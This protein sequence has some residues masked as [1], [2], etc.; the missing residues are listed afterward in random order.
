MAEGRG[1]SLLS[2]L[3]LISL[4]LRLTASL[5]GE[6]QSWRP[7]LRA[8][9]PRPPPPSSNLSTS[10]RVPRAPR[11][12]AGSADGGPAQ[13]LPGLGVPRLRPRRPC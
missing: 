5:P 4:S 11:L 9:A 2:S 10:I 12:R 1:S 8:R 3:R 6:L 7:G 13:L